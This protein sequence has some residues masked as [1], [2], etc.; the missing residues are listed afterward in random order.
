M[1]NKKIG[2]R[3]AFL[4]VG[5]LM[6][7][8]FS[9]NTASAQSS[10]DGFSRFGDTMNDVRR[11]DYPEMER[12]SGEASALRARAVQLRLER[13]ESE[14]LERERSAARARA[15]KGAENDEIARLS[16]LYEAVKQQP[17]KKPGLFGWGW[18]IGL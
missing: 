11:N 2:F 16:R 14:R 8:V 10:A 3:C 15:R 18:S 6:S 5:L 1:S 13:E 7:A 9:C 12:L 17:A 4:A